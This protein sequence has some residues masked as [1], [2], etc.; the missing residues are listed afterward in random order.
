LLAV[1]QLLLFSEEQSLWHFLKVFTVLNL[2]GL[3]ILG[4]FGWLYLLM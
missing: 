3:L 1:K 2:I 4:V